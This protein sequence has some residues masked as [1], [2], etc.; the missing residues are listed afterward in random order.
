MFLIDDGEAISTVT[1]VEDFAKGVLGLFLNE[2]AYNEDFNVVSDFHYSHKEILEKLFRKIGV[3]PNII[4]I[5]RETIAKYLPN[6]AE[7]VLG[8][9]ALNA[10]FDN[11]KLKKAIPGLHFEYNLEKGLDKVLQYYES[12]YKYSLID[13]KYDGQIDYLLKKHSNISRNYYKYNNIKGFITYSIFS[14]IPIK[15]MIKCQNFIK[16][17]KSIIKKK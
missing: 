16:K 12:N 9:R 15:I 6:Y 3:A 5:P 10:I 2:K 14:I 17:M 11:S 7:M 4:N 1:Y 8:D 13:Y